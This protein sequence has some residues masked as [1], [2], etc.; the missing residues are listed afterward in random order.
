MIK[1]FKN[2]RRKLLAEGKTTNYLKYAIGEIILV[3]IGIL[4]ALQL[5]TQK[6]NRQNAELGMKYLSEMKTEV[7]T[8]L[9]NIDARIR[10]LKEN[11]KNHEAALRT[12]NIDNLPLDSIV[13]IFTPENLDFKISELTFNKMKNLGVTA[14]TDNKPL[15]SEISNYY[16]SKVVKLNL[17]LDYVFEDLKKYQDYFVYQQNKIDF[18]FLYSLDFEFPSLYKQTK[19]ELRNE[20]RINCIKFI[21]SNEGRMII[22]G[23][24][25]NKRYSLGILED[26]KSSTQHLLLAIYE[27]LKANNSKIE[28]LLELPSDADFIAIVLDKETLNKYVG[29]YISESNIAVKVTTEGSKI[30]IE[31]TNGGNRSELIPTREDRFYTKPSFAITQFN[32]EKGKVLSLTRMLAGAKKDYVKND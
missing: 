1:L 27:E 8:D 28:P 2:F 4:I 16:N 6:E 11:I 17:G 23:D 12:S 31:P 5:N 32:T 29:N 14:L 24:L 22:L 13:M 9:F 10:K 19:E 25:G 20:T 18:N 15:N 26:F 3:V 7:Q 30:Y 21:T